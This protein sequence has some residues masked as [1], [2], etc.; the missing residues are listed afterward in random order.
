MLQWLRQPHPD[1]ASV[2]LR[3]G[4]AAIFIAHGVVKLGQQGGTDRHPRLTAGTQLAVAWGE[5]VCGGALLI[6]LLSRLAALGIIVIMVGAIVVQTGKLDFINI[7]FR[8]DR[9]IPTGCEYNFAIII[10]CMAIIVLGSGL[11][12]LDRLLFGSGK[13]ESP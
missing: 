13:P 10:M 3:L 7:E 6:G 11:F 8:M 1:L 9:E 5:V 4:L 12:S 2:L